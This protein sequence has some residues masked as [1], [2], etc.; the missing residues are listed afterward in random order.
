VRD[1]GVSGFCRRRT[2]RYATFY[3]V[4]YLWGVP[5]NTSAFVTKKKSLEIYNRTRDDWPTNKDVPYLRLFENNNVHLNIRRTKRSEFSF[6][7]LLPKW[8]LYRFKFE[9]FLNVTLTSSYIFYY[10]AG[11]I[12]NSS[13]RYIVTYLPIVIINYGISDY[14]AASC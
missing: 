2:E 14:T 11:A 13:W 7:L 4:H 5:N 9:N 10:V 12:Q 1:C 3:R 8:L 6:I